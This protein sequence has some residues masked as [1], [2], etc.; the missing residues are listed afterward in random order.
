MAEQFWT[1]TDAD[2]DAKLPLNWSFPIHVRTHSLTEAPDLTALQPLDQ[3]HYRLSYWYAVQEKSQATD[4]KSKAILALL[5][6]AR[7]CMKVTFLFCSSDE[8]AEQRKWRLANAEQTSAAHACL[9]GWK[10]IVGIVYVGR[11]LQAWSKDAN[12]EAISSWLQAEKVSVSAKVIRQMQLV[13]NRISAASLEFIMEDME[14]LSGVDHLLSRLTNLDLLCNLTKIDKNPGLQAAL[15]RYVFEDI[16]RSIASRVLHADANRETVVQFARSSLLSRRMV[17]YLSAKFKV[18]EDLVTSSDST[19]DLAAKFRTAHTV[20]QNF[21]THERLDASG[22]TSSTSDLT[23]C[24]SLLPFQHE[25]LPVLKQLLVPNVLVKDA[26]QKSIEKDATVSAEEA[27]QQPHWIELF[28][29]PDL[30]QAM[31]R[32]IKQ[33]A[34]PASALV[35]DSQGQPPAV[36]VAPDDAQPDAGAEAVS[37]RPFF[38]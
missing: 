34:V 3:D 36:Q 16:K 30:L 1:P 22:L 13:H 8:H 29:L 33:Q 4:E 31:D 6:A 2:L 5:K 14:N 9:R 25:V 24:S 38:S 10:R 20:W 15:L 19:P 12:P 23:W 32:D 37:L 21:A 17:L 11:S 28:R 18:P 26:L 7:Q 27:L 35:P